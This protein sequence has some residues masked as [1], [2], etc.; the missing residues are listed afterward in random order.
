ME[1][2][3]QHIDVAIRRN[4]FAW[5]KQVYAEKLADEYMAPVARVGEH[6]AMCLHSASSPQ[7]WQTWLEQHVS[8]DSASQYTAML[9]TEF[10]HFYLAIQAAIAGLG[11]VLVSVYMVADDVSQKILQA[12]QAFTADGSG[13]YLLA[14][15][16]LFEQ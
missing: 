2:A 3:A 13:Y 14:M 10:E 4:D 15:A 11:T 16:D 9:S 5:P 8:S 1:F 7:A 6:Q 12:E